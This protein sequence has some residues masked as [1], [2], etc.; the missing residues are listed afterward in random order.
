MEQQKLQAETVYKFNQNKYY[1]L[2]SITDHDGRDKSTLNQMY[3]EKINCIATYLELSYYNGLMMIFVEDSNG[4]KI[5]KAMHTSV[6]DKVVEIEGGL[7]VFTMNTIYTFEDVTIEI[8]DPQNIVEYA[9]IL[10]ILR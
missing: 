8:Q 7:Q 5:Y 3:A 9:Q 2:V 6:V 4:K 10:N 1:K